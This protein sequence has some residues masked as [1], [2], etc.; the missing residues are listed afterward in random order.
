[1]H[2]WKHTH[3]HT[4]EDSGLNRELSVQWLSWGLDF[5]RPKFVTNI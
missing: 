3:A 2:L 1:M 5:R 4:H